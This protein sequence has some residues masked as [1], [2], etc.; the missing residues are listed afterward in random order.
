MTDIA[1]L[2]H[3]HYPIYGP[4]EIFFEICQKCYE[5]LLY[6][7]RDLEHNF[8]PVRITAN[9]TGALLKWFEKERDDLFKAQ[10]GPWTGLDVGTDP[11]PH[12]R[13]RHGNDCNQDNIGVIAD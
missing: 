10:V 12:I 2:L 6:L 1:L 11:F 9:I 13:I 4:D 7:I 5:R 8:S 3:F